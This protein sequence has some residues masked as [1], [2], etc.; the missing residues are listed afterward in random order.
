MVIL[1]IN[2]YF[3]LLTILE[4]L[5]ST[6]QQQSNLLVNGTLNLKTL[7]SS[8]NL[9]PPPPLPTDPGCYISSLQTQFSSP[10]HTFS[11]SALPSTTTHDTFEVTLDSS[12]IWTQVLC[13]FSFPPPPY[14][15]ICF[16]PILLSPFSLS[17]ALTDKTF[18]GQ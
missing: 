11:T 2:T 14:V 3:I 12:Q 5:N 8:Y 13:D 9:S 16:V 18:S 4:K 17:Q 7:K 6:K 15:L 10:P 1:L